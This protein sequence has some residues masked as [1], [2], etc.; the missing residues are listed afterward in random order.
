MTVVETNRFLK[1]ARQ[2]IPESERLKLVAFVAV[3]PQAGDLIPGTGGVR[4]LRWHCRAK[5]SEAVHE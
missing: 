2:L 1:D 5:A 3:N 4:K